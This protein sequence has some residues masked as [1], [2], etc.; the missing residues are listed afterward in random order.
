MDLKHD[1]VTGILV[2]KFKE[3]LKLKNYSKK[4]IDSYWQTIIRYI[5]WMENNQNKTL[6]EIT[7]EDI[8]AYNIY[9]K[10]TN[11]KPNSIERYLNSVRQFFKWLE[12]ESYIFI[13]PCD[14]LIIPRAKQSL[15]VVLTEKE[16]NRLIQTPNVSTPQGIRDRA[17]LETL[18]STGLRIGELIDLTIFDI[19]T[20]SG[21]V[22][23]NKGKGGKDRFA[24]L[25]KAACH[26]LK[27][28]VTNV[29]PKFT[30]NQPRENHLFVGACW[31]RKIH[32]HILTPLIS[33][34]AKKAGI[35][36]RVIPH[37]FRHTFAT[38]LLDNDVDIFKI[39]QLLGHSRAT[40][41]QRYTKV[42]PKQIKEEHTKHH[43]R[44]KEKDEC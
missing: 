12:Q 30:K 29:R 1:S 6:K 36:K 34:Y 14:N 18:Y 44:E 31:G 17:I 25:T 37:T 39:Q 33:D 21:F 3:C 22:R 28:Y 5:L 15:P 2:I 4:S 43:P 32:P 19:D 13:N 11:L 26:W 38:H 35:K 16:I 42:S 9:L 8:L 40:T 41:T 20:A 7:R 23:V 24:P 27:E 10:E